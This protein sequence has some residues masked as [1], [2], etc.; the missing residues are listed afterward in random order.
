MIVNL[1]S[2]EVP[3]SGT[4]TFLVTHRFQQ[5]L[6]DGDIN[7][8]FTLDTHN[9]WGFGLWYAP[10]KNLNVGF[11]RSSYLDDY[12][13]SVQYQLPFAGCFAASLRVGE[14][15]RTQPGVTTPP[16]SS[17]F[18]QAI[19]AYDFGKYV[20]ITAVPTYLNRI[21]GLSETYVQV[22][23]GDESCKLLASGR[24]TCSGLY[25]NVFNVP[26]ALSKRVIRPP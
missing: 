20:R 11:S 14:D 2:V 15:C 16:I 25:E 10:L 6:Q 18:A 26:V 8:F 9:T 24:Y 1:P 21:N 4:L 23:P 7:N 22:P 5:P 19:L 13:A 17:F 3:P 12:E